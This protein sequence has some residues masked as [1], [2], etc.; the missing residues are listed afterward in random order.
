MLTSHQRT[1][2]YMPGD[3]IIRKGER[4]NEMFFIQEGTVE[5]VIKIANPDPKSLNPTNCH[6]VFLQKEDY[7][8]EVKT[9]LRRHNLIQPSLDC[10]VFKLKENF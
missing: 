3:K 6:K 8:G 1:C 2:I 10:F 9:I 5:V 7:F 4:G